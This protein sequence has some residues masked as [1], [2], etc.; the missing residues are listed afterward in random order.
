[1]SEQGTAPV[2]Q[3]EISPVGNSGEGQ[4]DKLP[5]QTVLYET[6][7]KLLNERKRDLARLKELEAKEREREEADARKRGDYENLIK[8]RDEALKAKDEEL[9]GIR[10]MI[11]RASKKNAV[12]EALGGN[13][14]SKWLKLIDVSDVAVNPETGEVDNFTVAKVA[15]SFTCQRSVRTTGR[16]R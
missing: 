10:D 6:H 11:H 2:G 3:P 13:I 5:R 14:D 4:A 9:N 15:E 8:A 7:E 12:I 1:M 16:R